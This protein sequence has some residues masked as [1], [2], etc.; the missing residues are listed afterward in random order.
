MFIF[1]VSRMH[2]ID[3]LMLIKFRN[4]MPYTLRGAQDT[5][6]AELLASNTWLHWPDRGS[7]TVEAVGHTWIRPRLTVYLS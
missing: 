4:I 7:R 6:N 3:E 5:N 1:V 2:F